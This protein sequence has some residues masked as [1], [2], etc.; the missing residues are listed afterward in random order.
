MSRYD[1]QM[2]LEEVGILGQ[3]NLSRAKV[4]CVGAGG[5]GSPILMYLAGAGIGTLGVIDGDK[6]VQSNLQRQ[7]LFTEDDL[8][9]SKA[10]VGKEKLEKINR[11]IKIIS[12]DTFLNA[13][14]AETIFKDFD[15]IID[16]TDNFD[17]KF[18]INTVAKKLNKSWIYGSVTGFEGRLAVFE[19]EGPCLQCLLPNAPKQ[20]PFS[21]AELGVIGAMVGWVGSVQALK[22][23]QYFLPDARRGNTTTE[24][25]VCDG[26]SYSQQNL[27]LQRNPDCPTCA[28]TNSLVGND[29][30]VE[31]PQTKKSIHYENSTNYEKPTRYELDLAKINFTPE[32]YLLLDL[33]EETTPQFFKSARRYSMGDLFTLLDVPK[34]WRESQL[35][36]LL[37]CEQGYKSLSALSFLR[38]LGLTNVSHIEGGI[39][40]WLH[41]E[42]EDN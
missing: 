21:C 32:D 3:K 39:S 24:L 5:L 30:N 26:L 13:D 12:Y 15:L 2:R 9:K 29:L 19:P 6:V 40:P 14:N 41:I 33:C 1:R 18:L 38:H 27:I 10:L 7:I 11:D 20:N 42:N 4:L 25:L 28:K 37:F 8:E 36:L 34:D 17:A 16:G 31:Y 22:A 35:P 23:I